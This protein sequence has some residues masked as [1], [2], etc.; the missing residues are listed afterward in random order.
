MKKKLISLFTAIMVLTGYSLPAFAEETAP[1]LT[2]VET[3]SDGEYAAPDTAV[4]GETDVTAETE[5]VTDEGDTAS[6]TADVST[7]TVD[8][9][10]EADVSAETEAVTDEADVTADTEADITGADG[11]AAVE[12]TADES[13]D[14]TASDADD[15]DADTPVDT[16]VEI[17]EGTAETADEVDTAEKTDA[18]TA[19]A[20]ETEDAEAAD[21]ETAEEELELYA[22]DWYSWDESTGTLTLSGHL[23][24][25]YYN[26]WNYSHSTLADKAGINSSD[27]KKIIVTPGTMTNT[28]S[29]GMFYWFS[30]LTEIEGL[31]NL[32]T[33]RSTNMSYMFYNCSSLTSLDLSSFDTSNVTNMSCMFNSCENLETVT[34]SD[35]WTTERVTNSDAM[36]F[37]CSFLTGG[38]GTLYSSSHTDKEYARIDGGTSNPG[39]FTSAVVPDWYE[40]SSSGTLILQNQLPD[41]SNTESLA[42]LA[43]IDPS[44]VKRIIVS[45]G[46]KTGASAEGMFENFKNLTEIQGLNNLDTSA[47]TNMQFMFI[48]CSSLTSLD[49]SSFD[50]SNVTSMADMFIRCSA[51][52]TL[53]LSSFD[54]S[55]VTNMFGMFG[56]CEG[57][58][59]ITVSDKWSTASVSSGIYGT[60][61]FLGCTKLKGGAGT[62]FDGT[63][64]DVTYARIDGGA[65]NPGYLTGDAVIPAKPSFTATPGNASVTVSWSAVSGAISYRV[66]HR[67]GTAIKCLKEVTGTSYT[68]TGLKNGTKYGFLVRAFNGTNGSPYTEAD[69]KYATPVGSTATPAK[70]TFT[71][72]P[73]NASVT[74]SW[75]AVSGATSYR[76][77]HRE[78]TAIKCLKEVTGTS[79]TDTGLKN[80]TKYGFLVRAFNGTNG[81]AYTEADWKY[82]TPVASATPAKPT[83]TATPGNASVTV[84]WNAVSGATS[85]RVYHREGTA[86]K[87]LKEVTGTSYTDTGL[88][89]GAKYGFLVRAFSGTNGSAYTEADWKYATPVASAT[90]AKPTFTAAGATGS[91]T[92]KWNAVSGA[93]SYR[94][95][96]KD[97]STVKCLKEVTGTSYTDTG[98]TNG[99]EYGFLVRAFSGTNGSS[100]TDADWKNAMPLAK[101]EFSVMQGGTNAVVK[102]SKVTG[103][104]QYRVYLIYSDGTIKAL[105][106]TTGTSYT[107]TGLS[108]SRYG[109]KY[110]FLVRAIN[111]SNGSSYT[112]E[113][114]IYKTFKTRTVV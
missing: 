23:P 38:A 68:D 47:C 4:T 104:A 85:Y 7:D 27:V 78:G 49:L 2:A 54:T 102:W 108:A 20:D 6:D 61:M 82:A 18:D 25:T 5:G 64:T 110:G 9:T 96:H 58:T 67:E 16:V 83:F 59:K 13:T 87:C 53:D 28:D 89:N 69:W 55:S 90:P 48:D 109:T 17:P 84:K 30:H 107:V 92:I 33:T 1:V 46:T 31:N 12:E 99:K 62:E 106:N 8:V 80:G 21:E 57:L 112:D 39:Y 43:G 113:D 91:V 26:S 15:S 66:Y 24:A 103:A 29:S 35:K 74:V 60:L 65:S 76:V 94:V 51:L 86:I 45:P 40:W 19:G 98:L 50:T 100:Y 10:D 37:G 56:G 32:D 36:F 75:S 101:P 41:T 3:P 14:D 70:P 97:G 63:K 93:T 52:T 79:Y 11:E 105:A 42:K 44:A 95:Y 34:V 71:A 22:G 72:T 88:K 114:I 81:S 111:G 73:G 77:Y